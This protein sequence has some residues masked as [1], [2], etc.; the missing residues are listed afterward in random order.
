MFS[1][2]P[3]HPWRLRTLM[4]ALSIVPSLGATH[5]AMA[6]GLS[7]KGE[8]CVITGQST[9]RA[10]ISAVGANG[11]DGTSRWFNPI[12]GHGSDGGSGG[13]RTLIMG[14]GAAVGAINVRTDGGKGGKGESARIAHDGVGGN[15]GN[16]GAVHA[17]IN[18][19][20]TNQAA[21]F[22][23]G[24]LMISTRGGA[25]GNSVDR[26]DHPTRGNPGKGGNVVVDMAGA[27]ISA[28]GGIGKAVSVDTSGGN[29]GAGRHLAAG[30]RESGGSGGSAG[31]LTVTA[32][33]RF[34]SGGTAMSLTA[35]GGTGGQIDGGLFTVKNGAGG[36][37][38]RGGV[39]VAN[40]GSHTAA[41]TDIRTT[42]TGTS[43]NGVAAVSRGGDGGQATGS[44]ALNGADGGQGGVG[45][46]VRVDLRH[47]VVQTSGADSVAVRAESVGGN[48]FWGG[49]SVFAKGGKAG[50]GGNA[51]AVNVT[52]ADDAVITTTGKDATGVRALS[53]GGGG[54]NGGKGGI[55]MG[56]GNGASGGKGGTVS[57]TSASRITTSGEDAFGIYAGSL[58][59]TAGDG[60][61]TSGLIALG[62]KG[63]KG[64]SSSQV[65]V[66]TSGSITTSGKG[67]H[68]I[69][70]QSIGGDGGSVTG[71]GTAA[72]G[73]DE[74]AYSP[75]S[76]GAGVIIDNR[77][78][79]TTL[80]DGAH[81]ILSQSLGG[82]GG[83]GGSALGLIS[84][85]GNGA[86][87]GDAGNTRI[88]N[89]GAIHTK[90]N[91][92]SAIAA[93]SVGGGGGNGGRAIAI[94][95]AQNIA[96]SL[97]G[98]GKSGGSGGNIVVAQSGVLQTEGEDAAAISLQSIGG[99]GGSG[100]SAT[101][102]SA[103]PFSLAIGGGAGVGGDGR[104]VSAST[105]GT[106]MT[107]GN[108]A[109][110][111]RAQSIG[112]G[113]GNGGNA[114][115]GGV[116]VL[117]IAIGGSAGSA[118]K[119][120][121][122]EIDNTARIFT[123]ADD[124]QGI[125]AQS[126]GGG[127]GI[128]GRA[129]SLSIAPPTPWGSAS[130]SL[131]IGGVAGNGGRADQ[132]RVDNQGEIRTQGDGALGVVAQSIGGGGGI[133]GS[134]S[135]SSYSIN[136]ETSVSVSVALGRSGGSGG[137][138]DKAAITNS[139]A[140]ST[141][142][143]LATAML[144]Q[145]IGGG[146]GIGGAATS[147]AVA[148]GESSFSAALSLGGAGGSGGNAGDVNVT[149]GGM[150]STTG[151]Q[152]RGIV[153]MSVGGGGGS[154]GSADG[155][156]RADT[157]SA[158]VTLGRKGGDGGNGGVVEV[159]LL[160]GDAVVTAGRGSDAVLAQS[161]GGG[162][163]IGSIVGA[164]DGTDWPELPDDGDADGGISGSVS[165][166]MGGAG[167]RG[168]SGGVVKLDLNG[169]IQA[170]GAQAAGV[171]AQSVGGGG[172]RAG[173]SR[174]SASGGD[175]SA[176]LALGRSGGEGGIGAD[177]TVNQN[178]TIAVTGA[179]GS[180]L[181][182]QS[183]GG[184]GG[185]GSVTESGSEGG[186]VSLDLS[187]GGKGG[188][189]G[190][191]GTV[192]VRNT[193]VVV[194]GNGTALIAQ[195]I[196]GGGG[197]AGAVQ[198]AAEI[199][200][201]DD[202][203][204][205]VDNDDDDDK[206][207]VAG[208]VALGASGGAGGNSGNI[209]VRN[210]G[211]IGSR[212][213]GTSAVL[214]QAIGGG[215]GMADLTSTSAS[216]DVSLSLALAGSGGA[217][218][219][220][221]E[222]KFVNE[223]T[224]L[225]ALDRSTAVLAQSV[226]GGGGTGGSSHANHG[227]G[228]AIGGTGG[229]GGKGGM[230]T[231]MHTGTIQTEGVLSHAVL[232]QSI[233][234]S[235]GLG[236]ATLISA[237]W[238]P[239]DGLPSIP[240]MAQI[241][242]NG[243]N[244]GNGGKVT[245]TQSGGGKV[246][247]NG[248]DA[249]GVMLQSIG[250]GGGAAAILGRVKT[251]VDVD[252][253]APTITI[254]NLGLTVGGKGGSGGDGGA[255]VASLDDSSS[256]VTQGDRATALLAQSVGGGGGT[257]VFS[258]TDATLNRASLDVGGATDARGNGGDILV[259]HGGGMMTTGV[260]SHGVLA[261]S[262]GGGG[263]IGVAAAANQVDAT[264]NSAGGGTGNGGD[265][266]VQLN[267]RG[268]IQ[269]RGDG[270]FGILAQSIGGGGGYVVD[271][272]SMRLDSAATVLPGMTGSTSVGSGGLVEV[273]VDGLI[274]TSGQR[275][276]GV[277]A[278]S[279]GG[280]GG[281]V[282]GQTGALRGKGDAGDINVRVNGT[283]L[284][285][286]EDSPGIFAQSASA[287]GN[288]GKL[289]IDV[290]S[291]GTVQGGA[292]REGAAIV[293][294]GGRD[295]TIRLAPDSHVFA[296]SG[297]AIRMDGRASTSVLNEGL[298][299]GSVLLSNLA[300]NTFSNTQ[301]GVFE[302]GNA[303][304]MGRGNALTN[305]GTLSPFGD[306]DYGTTRL[307]GDYRQA[308]TGVYVANVDFEKG[309]SDKLM[310][311]GHADLGGALRIVGV[312][313]LPGKEPVVLTAEGGI[314]QQPDFHI[315]PSA[316]FTYVLKETTLQTPAADERSLKSAFASASP[317]T[318]ISLSIDADFDAEK[319]GLSDDQ[320]MLASY[321]D[322][323]WTDASPNEL[324]EFSPVFDVL[325]QAESASDYQ[326]TLDRLANDAMQAPA[327]NLAQS[328]RRFLSR[329]MSCPEFMGDGVQM[330]EVDCFWG[331]VDGTHVNRADTHDDSGYRLDTVTTQFGGQ[332]R[333]G[334]KWLLGGSV[335]YESS[336]SRA[337]VGSLRT[338]GDAFS[339]G[340][341][342]K[343]EDGPWLIAGAL[344][345]GYGSYD[346]ARK[347]TP[348]VRA[349]SDWHSYFAGARVRAAYTHAFDNFYIKPIADVDLMYVRVPAYQERGAGSF[350]LHTSKTSQTSVM[351]SPAVEIGGRFDIGNTVLRPYFSVGANWV[352]DNRWTTLARFQG[353]PMDD[354]FSMSQ[355]TPRAF[356]E[357]NAGISIVDRHDV[358]L[359]AEVRQRSAH[360]YTERSGELRL[361]VRF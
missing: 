114:L 188:G 298:L 330:R 274:N 269:T 40:I 260:Q 135:A 329:M 321:V 360:R 354:R 235:G 45:G 218:G 240:V 184:G 245:W 339:A 159:K 132:V 228:L 322:R 12:P 149:N 323:K 209:D 182:A 91:G 194:A 183:V 300:S 46:D 185:M 348:Q 297:T 58:G 232:A 122:V 236:G 133:G 319:L 326:A 346:T 161:I 2:N 59:G 129:R 285:Q 226:G 44:S 246:F 147:T 178:G 256:I 219:H 18:G 10:T 42:G 112:G 6:D 200:D 237:E 26:K 271:G 13:Q 72:I 193:G 301:R 311:S 36:T 82:G 86:S 100:G 282:A 71:T 325:A 33:G 64:S 127:G 41:V 281:I 356:L 157:V 180:A 88:D 192:S 318:A 15:G 290:G 120:G 173:S 137:D 93:Q 242:G 11:R 227:I 9:Q 37:G 352:S 16:G 73:G 99:G 56:G 307:T 215:G 179:G 306:D 191:G 92:A 139:G 343:R 70:A 212:G 202:D 65:R 293:L 234:G 328:S 233:G 353:D 280:G 299:Q 255:V 305:A 119:A 287:N 190:H 250:G 29:G 204:F 152:A 312:N 117:T 243:G 60:G 350:N 304:R 22:S 259:T 81:G 67:A 87:G 324:G 68:A 19:K 264:L 349:K 168:G 303:I 4:T 268:E 3:G 251:S 331:K 309:L 20:I 163:G 79:L 201:D 39:I 107:S 1:G 109:A 223:N 357:L 337:D 289:S 94:Q 249:N 336:N 144:A 272:R 8:R 361:G 170:S 217:G 342:L 220:G 23:S 66:E 270:A 96:F 253:G 203:A 206:P 97:G 345:G 169:Q 113:G 333:I 197:I 126:I 130:A 95:G 164:E 28:N 261:Q 121:S 123:T 154:A 49:S 84:I 291:H 231:L 165:F 125:V 262:I 278:Q 80:G 104:N 320:E 275:A 257:A 273:A 134:A 51:G 17:T 308:S 266:S 98:R 47:A 359:R 63:G 83:N 118:G 167:G 310:V 171:L 302:S 195:S 74:K 166:A 238:S 52:L 143:D 208:V 141:A 30:G 276:A 207:T 110:G 78:E 128:G 32:N 316:V 105:A 315:E 57:V 158:S 313:H 156:V 151:S 115:S 314:T 177:V 43:A 279:I 24:G 229:A 140:V 53:V 25:A 14:A 160:T 196:G 61:G 75:D 111:I 198:G 284:A 248:D 76:D 258:D 224:V 254:Q 155:D 162:G 295:N 174:S 230:V 116:S 221:G 142:G 145:S 131:A 211:T 296:L 187:I 69:L 35:N 172:G 335:A 48:G 153:A 34:V 150:V 106:I 292:G 138:G 358:E 31:T 102:I 38:G 286:G 124:A 103:M 181:V 210:A 21:L 205:P 7:C 351:L 347:L 89:S 189:G 267:R 344:M 288:A 317:A 54:H 338:E 50:A 5:L 334:E 265:V 247:T 341:V 241:G 340:V 225:T 239:Q 175:V 263:G 90:G 136:P 222:I 62:G 199:E 355:E 214:L 283:V 55:L 327:A 176:G 148:Y 101:T 252:D 186:K 146:G 27:D 108:G 213:Q 332:R 85:G 77:A 277:F 294:S 244:G 216:G